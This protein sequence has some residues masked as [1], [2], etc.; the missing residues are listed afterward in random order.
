MTA[1]RLAALV[2]AGFL[3]WPDSG[4]SAEPDLELGA[5]I[6]DTCA[7]CHGPYG[8]GGG[9]GV[10]PRL[11]GMTPAYTAQQIRRFKS[12]ERENIPMIP[13]AN[14]RELPEEDV[15]AVSAYLASLKLMTQLPETDGV[16]DGLTRL[17]QA[18][19]VLMIP[20]YPGNARKGAS[21]YKAD[22]ARCHGKKA[23]G[24]ERGPRLSGQ[25]IR[26][27]LKQIEDFLAGN[28]PH[29]SIKELFAGR[30]DDDMLMVMAFLSTLDDGG[31]EDDEDDEDDD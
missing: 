3:C 26:Y 4:N 27:L 11:A 15:I 16:I 7:P 1:G 19:Q 9:G 28:R 29:K 30:P 23:L 8:Q 12:R 13:Y 2:L 25:H 17:K 18:K 24:T 5:E 22:C 31:G 21:I 20:R 14:E 6:Y 10:Y